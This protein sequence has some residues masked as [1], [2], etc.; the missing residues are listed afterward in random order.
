MPG[1]RAEGGETPVAAALTRRILSL[2]CFPEL[3]DEE[4]QHVESALQ[5]WEPRAQ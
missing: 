2:P 4:V 5:E 3:T 1:L